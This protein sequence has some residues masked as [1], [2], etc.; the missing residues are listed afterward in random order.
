MSTGTA[1][2]ATACKEPCGIAPGE[3]ALDKPKQV[4]QVAPASKRSMDRDQFTRRME[5]VFTEIMAEG[6]MSANE[7]AVAALKRVR[8]EQL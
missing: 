3:I 2:V 4:E 1:A 6:T 7:A 8:S 5:A